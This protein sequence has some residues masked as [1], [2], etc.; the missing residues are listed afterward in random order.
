MCHK[1]GAGQK[2]QS[3]GR[4]QKSGGGNWQECKLNQEMKELRQGIARISNELHRRKSRRKASRKKEVI[5]Q[6]L[7]TKL[8][9]N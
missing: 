9:I 8:N 1:L 2:Q 4:R 3:G 5:I 7:K 6:D